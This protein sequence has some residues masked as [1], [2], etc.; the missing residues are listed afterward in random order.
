MKTNDLKRIIS[1]ASKAEQADFVIKNCRV[2]NVFTHTVEQADIAFCGDKIAGIGD[3][4]G[5]EEY[6][7][8]GAYALPGLIDS[9]IHIESSML[10]PEAFGAAVVPHGT[11]TVIADPHEI[12]NVF[13][14]KALDYMH[15]ASQQTAL[16]VRFM[17]PSCVPCTEWEDAGAA[18]DAEDIRRALTMDGI[19]GVGEF[20][21]AQGVVNTDEEVLRKL[22]AAH[23]VGAIIDGHAPGLTKDQ[24]AGY[25]AAGIHTDHECG[26]AEEM[27]ERLSRGMYVQLRYGSACKELPILLKGLT[28]ENARRCLLC[29]DDRQSLTLLKD[30][31]I[32]DNLRICVKNGIDPITAIQMATLNAAE[33]YHLYDRGAI[34]PG[35]R[36]DV[37][38]VDDL[39]DFR[40]RHVWI[41][42]QLCASDGVYLLPTHRADPGEIGDSMHVRDF[43][44]ERLTLKLSNPFVHVID[45][46]PGTVLSGNG[47]SQIQL[48]DS[49]D[50]CFSKDLDVVRISVI[51]RH[52]GTGNV[53]N[54]FIRGYGL[55]RGAIAISIGH[56]SH[57]ILVVGVSADE[58]TFA[59]ERLIEQKGGI[60][61]VNEGSV[62]HTLPLPIG[63]LMSDRDAEFVADNLSQIE[64]IAVDQL[65]VDKRLDPIIS[66][67]FM[68]LPVIP[69]LKITDRGLFD[70]CR[71]Q[72]IP[73]EA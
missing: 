21:N 46:T 18:L 42:G 30:G 67:C 17:V 51:E 47:T 26:T 10:T 29:S 15:R 57:N 43:S 50:F 14:M 68:T 34:A 70:V 36:A 63:G 72:F 55:Q 41:G 60:V 16:N 8:A 69:D 23:E 39:T 1:V 27:H 37:I 22:C 9:H 33:C 24:L 61:L 48:T 32:D 62:L 28:S 49:G 53:A 13:G 71:Q 19:G 38:L 73:I 31:E 40:V 44:R 52:H 54:G 20:M 7:A 4:S 2:V 6:D 56:D 45:I 5:K 35:R 58:M 59:V 65:G 66:L 11:T 12:A 25:I 64:R 3:Y